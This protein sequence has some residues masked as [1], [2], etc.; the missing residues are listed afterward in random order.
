V[1]PPAGDAITILLLGND[2]RPQETGI[3]RT[4]TIMLMRLDPKAQRVA[5]FSLPRDM[6]V[7]IPGY[8]ANRINAAYVWGEYYGAPGGGLQLAR[9]TVSHLLNIPVDYAIMADFEGFIGLIDAIG[10][11]VVHVEKELHDSVFP[12]MNYGYT[13][14]HFAPGRQLMNGERALTYSRIRHPDSDF[15]RTRRQQAVIVAIGERLQERGDLKNLTSLTQI[16]GALRGFVQTDMPEERILGLAWA[17]RNVDVNTI[18]HVGVSSDMVSWGVG[19]DRYALTVPRA[20][21]QT[22]TE[23]FLD[24]EE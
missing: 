11:V 4:D 23:A 7:E 9:E 16:T 1:P 2:R 18:T 14:V 6:W 5:L 22:L 10:G 21:L 12:T 17:F 20:T 13:T 8:G 24:G 15:M 19:G 3:P